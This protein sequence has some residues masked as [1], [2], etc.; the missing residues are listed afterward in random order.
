MCNRKFLLFSCCI[1]F[2]FFFF[3]I[4]FLILLFL[5]FLFGVSDYSVSFRIF[6]I[7]ISFVLLPPPQLANSANGSPDDLGESVLA[8]GR[9]V[10]AFMES[11]QMVAATSPDVTAQGG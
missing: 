10:P 6:F 9:A 1:I 7:E 3:L 5:I 11:A 4:N 8:V 2:S